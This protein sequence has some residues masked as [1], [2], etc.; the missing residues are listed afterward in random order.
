MTNLPLLPKPSAPVARNPPSSSNSISS[1]GSLQSPDTGDDVDLANPYT[2]DWMQAS[3]AFNS[4]DSFMMQQPIDA[5]QQMNNAP[6][7]MDPSQQMTMS[8]QMAPSHQMNMS[9]SMD[10]SQHLGGTSWGNLG[11]DF[12]NPFAMNYGLTGSGKSLRVLIVACR[13]T[14]P[15]NPRRPFQSFQKAAQWR[16]RR[17]N[18]A[19][20]VAASEAPHGWHAPSAAAV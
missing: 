16:L 9:Q 10:S 20:D 11:Q 17:A 2:G 18:V 14:D 13:Y 4:V 12:H 1:S 19:L 6:Q 7:Q 5:L 15:I 8:H 3:N